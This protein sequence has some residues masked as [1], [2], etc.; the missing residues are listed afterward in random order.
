MGKHVT[1]R[2]ISIVFI[3]CGILFVIICMMYQYYYYH[4]FHSVDLSGYT[5]A[6][7]GTYEYYIDPIE[8]DSTRGEYYHINGWVA[9][10][11]HTMGHFN[12]KL[13]LYNDNAVN[14]YMVRLEMVIRKDVTDYFNDGNSYDACGFQTYIDSQ[15]V[16][17]KTYKIG[18][19]YEDGE[20]EY[21]IK[22]DDM[23][24]FQL[25]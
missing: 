4:S 12:T 14:G 24:S 25:Y 13:V 2:T 20:K 1:K 18:F 10:T 7:Q 16:N 6:D 19:I 21:L 22:T 3:I 11:G 15:Y 9:M 5:I 17:G 23:I 8:S